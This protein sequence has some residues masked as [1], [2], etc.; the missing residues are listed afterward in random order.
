MI[1]ELLNMF[2][3]GPPLKGG[4]RKTTSKP[5][6]IP[7]SRCVRLPRKKGPY[8]IMSDNTV[9]RVTPKGWVREGIAP[10]GKR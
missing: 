6:P 9:Y 10:G 4:R 7:P 5:K 2:M 8:R 1:S 3:P